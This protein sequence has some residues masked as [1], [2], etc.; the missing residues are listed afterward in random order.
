MTSPAVASAA[1]SEVVPPVLSHRDTHPPLANA[2]WRIG[3]ALGSRVLSRERAVIIVHLNA[4]RTALTACKNFVR[5]ND[6]FIEIKPL[7]CYNS[8]IVMD[9]TLYLPTSA[10]FYFLIGLLLAT[11]LIFLF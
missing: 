4:R 3:F 6:F 8:E 10:V 11:S 9:F 7:F 1:S 5:E 2:S